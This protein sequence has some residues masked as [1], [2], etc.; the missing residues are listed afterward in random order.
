MRTQKNNTQLQLQ[1]TNSRTS[2]C[3]TLLL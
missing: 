2:F 3:T 1:F